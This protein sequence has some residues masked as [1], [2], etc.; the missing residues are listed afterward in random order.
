MGNGIGA[1]GSERR[2]GLGDGEAHPAD[3]LENALL[4]LELHPDTLDASACVMYPAST[5]AVRV[6]P[7]GSLGG[8]GGGV[9]QGNKLNNGR[10]PGGE[11]LS[12]VDGVGA[13]LPGT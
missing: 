11:A 7:F 6:A 12:H 4:A 1:Q 9:E 5:I 2:S 3:N 8:A 13:P 10:R